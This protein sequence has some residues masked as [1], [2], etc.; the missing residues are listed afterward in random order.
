MRRRA[1]VWASLR[2]W[3][4]SPRSRVRARA[5]GSARRRPSAGRRSRCARGARPAELGAL[6]RVAFAPWR[7][8]RD[9]T[10]ETLAA[11]VRAGDRRALA[12]AI[13]L[14]ENG[15][16]LAYELVARPLPGH[17]PRVLGRRH[18]A[19]RRRQVVPHRRARPPRARAGADRR[20]RSR[21]TRRARSRRAR[22]SATGSGSTDHFLDPGVFI[23]SMGTRGHLGGLA[24]T[25][26][27]AMLVLD[28]AGQGSALPRDRRRGA[29][30]GRGDR[31][32]PTPCCSCSCP[33]PATPC[34]R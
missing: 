7:G 6:R 32:S 34:R 12:R 18:R 31:R 5:D 10:R 15:D 28:A 17:R 1:L 4:V 25:T 9:W 8:R 22:C 29:E 14:V 26:L 16:P 11:G 30:R 13:T 19:A 2:C 23:R 24:E 3:R 21:S 20:R 27:Q 33:A